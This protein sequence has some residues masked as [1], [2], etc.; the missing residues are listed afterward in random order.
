MGCCANTGLC[1]RVHINDSLLYLRVLLLQ[2]EEAK[3]KGFQLWLCIPGL[4]R[5]ILLP[6]SVHACH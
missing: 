3:T 5:N 2:R 4:T 1:L 6:V